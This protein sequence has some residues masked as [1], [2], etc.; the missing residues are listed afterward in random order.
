MFG[1]TIQKA[2]KPVFFETQKIRVYAKKINSL[3]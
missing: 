2:L 1:N 3:F